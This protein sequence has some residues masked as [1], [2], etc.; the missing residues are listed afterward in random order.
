[1]GQI[2]D[3]KVI[4]YDFDR[5]GFINT[6][7]GRTFGDNLFEA[8]ADTPGAREAKAGRSTLKRTAYLSTLLSRSG[9]GQ[10][11]SR[12]LLE[13]VVRQLR[14]GLEGNHDYTTRRFVDR[15]GHS[16]TDAIF[17]RMGESKPARKAH[18]GGYT[19]KRA[20]YLHSLSSRAGEAASAYGILADIASELRQHLKDSQLERLFYSRNPNPPTSGIS[21]GATE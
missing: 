19:L 17:Q 1:M 7:T 20:A 11:E 5:R 10:G 9:E 16:V 13:D 2:P 4:R 3:L 12:R 21:L 15:H 18:A 8:L 6:D 14:E